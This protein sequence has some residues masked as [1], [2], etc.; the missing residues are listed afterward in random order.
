MSAAELKAKSEERRRSWL[1]AQAAA[2]SAREERLERVRGL[3][4][5]Y[6]DYDGDETA[7][8]IDENAPLWTG[9]S[10]ASRIEEHVQRA[11]D[12]GGFELPVD[13]GTLGL[14]LADLPMTPTGITL[15]TIAPRHLV[16]E[17]I[18]AHLLSLG[19]DLEPGLA[20]AIARRVT[21]IALNR[22]YAAKDHGGSY[23]RMPFWVQEEEEK[24]ARSKAKARPKRA[25]AAPPEPK[26]PA[27]P[28]APSS[29][30]HHGQLLYTTIDMP[31]GP[32]REMCF[33][34]GADGGPTVRRR[35][36]AQEFTQAQDL[37]DLLVDFFEKAKELGSA[38]PKPGV[39]PRCGA[40]VAVAAKAAEEHHESHAA[41]VHH[42]VA[43]SSRETIGRVKVLEDLD[44]CFGRDVRT[45]L[46]GTECDRLKLSGKEMFP[47]SGP[48]RVGL[49][50][51]GRLRTVP[52]TAVEV[53]EALA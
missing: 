22:R 1:A 32:E 12:I 35:I 6:D 24:R 39:C 27:P 47:P 17:V 19:L 50:W 25:E 42:A 5:A 49:L 4:A 8:S 11:A 9:G 15:A 7:A 41:A 43:E 37:G 18:H 20:R 10:L 13:A 38:A 28:Q 40:P 3:V 29:S 34:C 26:P 14:W 31:D 2:R 16:P 53:V 52:V 33:A 36:T 44:F 45:L 51:E 23:L 46:A 21:L 30:F 48:E